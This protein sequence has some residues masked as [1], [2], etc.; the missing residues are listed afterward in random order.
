METF[1]KFFQKKAKQQPLVQP[2]PNSHEGLVKVKVKKLVPAGYQ[3]YMEEVEIWVTPEEAEKI[4]RK[5]EAEKM[6]EE[7][8]G[9]KEEAER[10]AYKQT[11]ALAKKQQ[12]NKN[13]AK[14][15]EFIRQ[16][17]AENASPSGGKRYTRKSK[18]NRRKTRRSKNQRKN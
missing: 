15:K 1:K 4:H 5:Q 10:V 16:A 18:V 11:Q 7:A 9:A 13:V 17:E 2:Q 6:N 8:R 3:S 12:R 14:C